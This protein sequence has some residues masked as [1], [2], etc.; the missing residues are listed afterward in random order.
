MI[1]N[2][3][4]RLKGSFGKISTPTIYSRAYA[5]DYSLW[6][7]NNVINIR[8]HGHKDDIRDILNT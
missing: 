7:L 6:L 5:S 8:R 3:V 2:D 4:C 1:E